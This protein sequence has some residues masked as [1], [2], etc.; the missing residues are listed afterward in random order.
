MFWAI[1]TWFWT[2][3]WL[4]RFLPTK[5]FLTS[6]NVKQWS[7]LSYIVSTNNFDT[8][9]RNNH[10]SNSSRCERMR[11]HELYFTSPWRTAR[12]IIW[13]N[14][15]PFW[16]I[17]EGF[18]SFFSGLRRCKCRSASSDKSL[19]KNPPSTVEI[20]QKFSSLARTHYVGLLQI[21]FHFNIFVFAWAICIIN[22]TDRYGLHIRHANHDPK[23]ILTGYLCIVIW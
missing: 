7:Y 19:S 4:V 6:S 18:K 16:S 1:F 2:G 3:L 14:G 22:V 17:G 20:P 12:P 15:R 21:F 5:H 13:F 8:W 10:L 23:I 9:F 11:E